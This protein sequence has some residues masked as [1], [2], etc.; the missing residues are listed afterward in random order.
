MKTDSIF[1]QIFLN[2]PTI[3]F[4]LINQ[5]NTNTQTYEFTSRE[6]K[7]LSFRLDGLF[8]PTDNNPN[9]PFYLVEVQFQP[10][11][12]LYYRL[13]AELFL[14]LRQYQPPNPWQV[15]VIYPS[16]SIEREQDRHFGNILASSQVQRIYLDELEETVSGSLG[17]RVVKLVVIKPENQ[18]I[19]LAKSLISQAK[20]EITEQKIQQDLIDLIETIIVYKLPQKTRK[21][22][23]AM[24]GLSELKKTKVYQ[25]AFAEGK[26]EGK[27]EGKVE[28]NLKTVSNMIRLGLSLEIIAQSL[29]LSLEEVQKLVK[30]TETTD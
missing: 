10:D 27:V 11:D 5:P 2:F 7:Q 3:F 15:V 6:V 29:E 4:E 1:Y 18:A 8:L 20:Q 14:F 9:K 22:I 23:E 28:A 17:I 24:L 21:E 26:D 13:F 19:N 12:N 30:Q 25:E 16:R